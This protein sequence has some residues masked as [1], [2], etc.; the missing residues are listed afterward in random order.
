VIIGKGVVFKGGK[1]RRN[2]RRNGIE[3]YRRIFE[4]SSVFEI[5]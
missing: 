3:R 4:G 2:G 1:G 5:V